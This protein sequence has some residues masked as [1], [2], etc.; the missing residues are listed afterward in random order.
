MAVNNAMFE[1]KQT[2]VHVGLLEKHFEARIAGFTS[3][4]YFE[5]CF[6]VSF[7]HEA[8]AKKSV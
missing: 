7:V 3:A 2:H 8:V 1:G 6:T 5:G 4:V